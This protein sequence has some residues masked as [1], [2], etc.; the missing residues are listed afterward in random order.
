MRKK[1]FT[2]LE[3]LL[4]LSIMT[5]VF[6]AVMGYVMVVGRTE[7]K[8][9]LT[10]DRFNVAQSI[11]TELKNW[12][13]SGNASKT[14]VSLKEYMESTSN[15]YLT[16]IKDDTPYDIESGGAGTYYLRTDEGSLL[17]VVVTLDFMQEDTT[18]IDGDGVTDELVHSNS[19]QNI[20]RVSVSVAEHFKNMEDREYVWATA[21]GYKGVKSNKPVVDTYFNDVSDDDMV[22]T[23]DGAMLLA[24]DYRKN[25]DIINGLNNTDNLSYYDID[26]VDNDEDG[27]TDYLDGDMLEADSDFK[28]NNGNGIYDEAFEQNDFATHYEGIIYSASP[29]KISSAILTKP[30][31][32]TQDITS[33]YTANAEKT[34]YTWVV[35]NAGGGTFNG[36]FDIT[37]DTPNGKWNIEVTA[38]TNPEQATGVYL[39]TRSYDFIVDTVAPA[40]T[41]ISPAPGTFVTSS[42]VTL[43]VT[44]KDSPPAGLEVPTSGLDRIYIF[45]KNEYESGGEIKYSW[46]LIKHQLIEKEATDVFS[47]MNVGVNIEG[48][49]PGPHYYRVVIKDRSGNASSA[50][51]EVYVTEEPDTKPPRIYPLSPYI[52]GSTA[53]TNNAEV[54][55]AARIIDSTI[56]NGV[57]TETGVDVDPVNGVPRVV[58]KVITDEPTQSVTWDDLPGGGF[59][60]ISAQ[61]A[62]IKNNV[63]NVTLQFTL[64]TVLEDND[65]VLVGIYAQD[66]VLNYSTNEWKFIYSPTAADTKPVIS[67]TSVI[68][69][70]N[71]PNI[72][73]P[74][75]Y[76]PDWMLTGDSQSN[77]NFFIGWQAS[78]EN[79]IA[80]VKLHYTS[81]DDIATLHEKAATIVEVPIADT[82]GF[83]LDDLDISSPGTFYFYIQVVDGS[84]ESAYYYRAS[85][86]ADPD[87]HETLPTDI[88]SQW[89]PVKAERIRTLVFDMDTY[90]SSGSD[91]VQPYYTLPDGPLYWNDADC[92]VAELSQNVDVSTLAGYLD[93][94][95]NG[96]FDDYDIIIFFTGNTAQPPG[97]SDGVIQLLHSFMTAP[98][99]GFRS[100]EG[101]YLEG[102]VGDSDMFHYTGDKT[103][104]LSQY[105]SDVPPRIAFIGKTFFHEF[106]SSSIYSTQLRN[107]FIRRWLG[108]SLTG[109]Q[110]YSYF[111]SY[112]YV[113]S[114]LLN[115]VFW[116]TDYYDDYAINDVIYGDTVG[117]MKKDDEGLDLSRDSGANY[118][119]HYLLA[120]LTDE[121]YD[122]YSDQAD[123]EPDRWALASE[124]IT[125]DL[126]VEGK[127][128]LANPAV[129]GYDYSG[130]DHYLPAT[131]QSLVFGAYPQSVGYTAGVWVFRG[132]EDGSGG[133]DF[134]I[135]DG[136][137]NLLD[138]K[139]V[140]LGFGIEAISTENWRYE[141][142]KGLLRFLYY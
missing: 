43:A 131:K 51:T 127:M 77:M 6:I 110:T 5:T 40:V 133:W 61:V 74:Y 140:Y 52:P 124:L 134:S 120:P 121:Y 101:S 100:F 25:A 114:N 24:M 93:A 59:T 122:G 34:V 94:D 30:D 138:T 104:T 75:H 46:E 41:E 7:R 60:D 103:V 95:S 44:A 39:D 97:F 85:A 17:K 118:L 12:D 102:V 113:V 16:Y 54:T 58:Y 65:V 8:V 70:A 79:G 136:Q 62:Y 72:Q 48:V 128:L 2:F 1:G 64:G 37:D 47:S 111:S 13:Y 123:P 99:P 107:Y 135:D 125:G 84:G 15:D 27:K 42:K 31:G 78:D 50:E 68:Q 130:T 21:V 66:K 82:F 53:Y 26:D 4:G 112:P 14:L 69:L 126:K 67:E 91:N 86:S 28:D 92:T 83:E 45:E 32:T 33:N 109:R 56:I 96:K 10:I 73:K 63:N 115:P 137:R 3:L 98:Y 106:D 22:I 49:P 108:F 71:H 18:D 132:I 11:L 35:S 9:K 76:N 20:M 117:E 139:M 29:I 142:M 90:E 81:V 55:V 141:S 129:H 57:E 116:V 88:S 23:S 36:G 19:D 119:R 87:N 105:D 38:R 80:S 89:I